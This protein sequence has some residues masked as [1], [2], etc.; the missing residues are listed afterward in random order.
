MQVRQ[1]HC[2]LC[3]R[4]LEGR[5][6]RLV[7]A[8]CLEQDHN[9]NRA[10]AREPIHRFSADVIVA[11]RSDIHLCGNCLRGLSELLSQQPVNVLLKSTEFV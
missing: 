4:A 10:N 6:N 11:S 8:V 5:L 9:L 2:N 1:C 3:S 7:D